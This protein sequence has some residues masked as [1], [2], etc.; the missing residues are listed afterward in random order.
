MLLAMPG[1]LGERL[2]LPSGI[3]SSALALRVA[4]RLQGLLPEPFEERLAVVLAAVERRG[5]QAVSHGGVALLLVPVDGSAEHEEIASAAA[6]ALVAS[7]LS[8]AAPAEPIGEPLLAL[9]EALS[10]GGALALASLPASLRPVSGWQEVATAR[11]ALESFAAMA[12]AEQTPWANR[13]AALA[14]AGRPGGATPAVAQA[15]AGLLECLG[16]PAALAAR[17]QTLLDAWSRYEGK[18]CPKMPRVLR[19]AL[20]DPARAGFP[21]ADARS[22]ADAVRASARERL[23]AAG[24]VDPLPGGD[25]SPNQALVLAARA[26]GVGGAGL[27]PWLGARTVA[28]QALT[29]CRDEEPRD[30]FLLARP[31]PGHGFE[32]AWV[33]HDGSQHPVVIW[34]RWV[35]APTLCRQGSSVCFVDPRGVWSVSLDG[36]TPPALLTAGSYRLLAASPD[37]RRVAAARWP[38]AEVWVGDERGAGVRIPTSG[39]SGLAWVDREVLA[40]AD[41]THIGLFSPSGEGRAEALTSPGTT[42]ISARAGKVYVAESGSS[43]AALVRVE[44]GTGQRERLTAAPAAVASLHAGPDGSLVMATSLGLWRWRPGEAAQR[45]SDGLSV[46]P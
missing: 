2:P 37:L 8:P 24:G 45:F 32:V 21:P 29:G 26:R 44:L 1:G 42:A 20:A 17:P 28:P 9:G 40:V 19:R 35:L 3:D 46:G 10:H 7:A 30:G 41:G 39:H 38:E 43:G 27:C 23:V 18:D 15:A 33:A 22:E 31:L 5:V 6:E 25:F 4:A 11:S 16:T 34:P 36:R 13:R 14:S 12:L